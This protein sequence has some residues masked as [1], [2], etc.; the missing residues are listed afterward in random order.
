MVITFGVVIAASRAASAA[1]FCSLHR[2]GLGCTRACESGF[3]RDEVE[4]E[5]GTSSVTVSGVGK[6][7]AGGV[8]QLGHAA[9]E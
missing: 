7:G 2:F 4:N 9:R 8:V 6:R 3:H 1:P 5:R